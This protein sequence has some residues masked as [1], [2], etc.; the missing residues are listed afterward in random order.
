MLKK[1]LQLGLGLFKGSKQPLPLSG[2]VAA[3]KETKKTKQYVK[4]VSY[5]ISG[6]IMLVGLITMAIAFIRGQIT[7]EEFMKVYLSAPSPL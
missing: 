1:V 2:I 3:I 4:L 6:G 7:F 5:I